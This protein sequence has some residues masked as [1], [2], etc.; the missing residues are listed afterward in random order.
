MKLFTVIIIGILTSPFVFSSEELDQYLFFNG[1]E[2]EKSK[3]SDV[4]KRFGSTE[5]KK[6]G[7]AA[8]SY[9]GICYRLTNKNSTVYFESGEMGGGSII[10]TFKVL[11][12]NESKFLCKEIEEGGV[13]E[14]K[15]GTLSLG[16]NLSDAVKSLPI[17]T[18]SR[19]GLRFTY[20][21]KRPF[22]KQQL[23]ET[24]IEGLKSALWDEYITID[25]IGKGNLL[26]GFQV[27]K[28]TVW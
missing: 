2:L 12:E 22:T 8:D 3:I 20:W 19:R 11:L 15:L 4:Q 21:N 18:H 6:E 27:S 24:G 25:L 13:L 10:L 5:V 26:T 9:T 23:A 17:N 1:V 28:V 7:D 14:L 16:M